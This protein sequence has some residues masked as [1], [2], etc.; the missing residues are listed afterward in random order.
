MFRRFARPFHKVSLR[1][2][3]RKGAWFF[4][5]KCSLEHMSDRLAHLRSLLAA[6]FPGSLDTHFSA[7]SPTQALTTLVPGKWV[8]IVSFPGC[9]GES[10]LLRRFCESSTGPVALV[11]GADA[12]DPALVTQETRQRLLWVRCHRAAEAVRATD[13]LLRDGNVSTVLMDLRLLP[14]RELL[15]QPSSVWHRLR[16]LAEHAQVSAGIFSPGRVVPCAA[17]R[18][19]LEHGLG[20]HALEQPAETLAARLQPRLFQQAASELAI[21]S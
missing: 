20:L 5:K 11:D 10:L 14:L 8:E 6:R 15:R 4:K 17:R 18:W 12:F 13:L 9:G 7:A 16:M 21:A 3:F 1:L 19:G 2:N